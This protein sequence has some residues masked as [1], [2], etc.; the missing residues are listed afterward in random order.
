MCPVPHYSA[1]SRAV[2]RYGVPDRNQSRIP[3]PPYWSLCC[4]WVLAPLFLSHLLPCPSSVPSIPHSTF[5]NSP[6]PPGHSAPI[7]PLSSRLSAHGSRLSALPAPPSAL[8]A[9][10]SLLGPPIPLDAT[11]RRRYVRTGVPVPARNVEGNAMAVTSDPHEHPRP[12]GKPSPGAV[13]LF[14]DVAGER[15]V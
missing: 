4:P 13:V 3:L 5:R 12:F 9:R 1:S 11:H 7:A 8:G 10:R 6:A 15:K 14:G 2:P